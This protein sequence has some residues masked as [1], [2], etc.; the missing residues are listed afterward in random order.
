MG[1]PVK[2]LIAVAEGANASLLVVGSR[3]MS[4][5][6]RAFLGS[7]SDQIVRQAPACLVGR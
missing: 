6:E 1:H 2:R 5:T 4:Y 7:V 3:G